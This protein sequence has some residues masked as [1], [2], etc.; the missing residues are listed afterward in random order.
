MKLVSCLA[1]IGTL[2]GGIVL[3]MLI[4]RF[5]PSVD[6]LERLYGAIFLSVI[7]TMGL[8]VYNFSALNWRK[9]LV[10]SYSWWLLPLFLMMAGWVWSI[11]RLSLV[12]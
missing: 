11:N 5:Y 12:V 8:L 4:A 1:V 2:I 9:L 3:S 10:R 7:T 6:P